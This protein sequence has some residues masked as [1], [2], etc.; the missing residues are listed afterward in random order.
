MPYKCKNCSRSIYYDTMWRCWRHNA[1]L[2]LNA[3]MMP[4]VIATPKD[5]D[6]QTDKKTKK[7]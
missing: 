3:C 7:K 2:H 4:G 1:P 5:E 6:I